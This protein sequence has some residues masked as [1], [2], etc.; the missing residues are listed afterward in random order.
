MTLPL[1][2]AALLVAA[3]L[4]LPFCLIPN[5]AYQA[6]ERHAVDRML[7]ALPKLERE[8]RLVLIDIDEN[9]L[10]ETGPWPWPRPTVARLVTTLTEHYEVALLGLDV[11]FPEARPGD[12]L[13]KKALD[14]PAVVLSQVFDFSP[15]SETRTGQLA[16]NESAGDGAQP[17]VAAHGYIANHPGLMPE[18]ASIGHISPHIDADGKVRRLPPR[19]CHRD[20][21]CTLALGLRM[22]ETLYRT[23]DRRFTPGTF[24]QT[25]DLLPGGPRIPLDRDRLI[26]VPY[27][28]E[29]GGFA[30]VSAS[31]ILAR[32]LEKSALRGLPV[33][34][35]GTALSLGDRIV[36]PLG[37]HTPGL[38]IHAHLLSAAL[39]NEFIVPIEPTPPLLATGLLLVGLPYLLWRG[40]RQRALALLALAGG[41]IYLLLAALLRLRSGWALPLAPIPLLAIALALVG[42]ML[43]RLRLAR[44]LERIAAESSH[45]LPAALVRRL[46]NEK[47]VAAGSET[48][49]LSVLVADLRGFTRATEDKTPE[50]AARLVQKSLETLSEVIA[51]HGGT[52]EKYTGDGLMAIW[53]APQPDPQHARHAL[54]AALALRE[55]IHRLRPWFIENG[56]EPLGIS[57][58]INTGRMAV[59]IFGGS[60]RAWTAHGDAVNLATRI[61]EL[62]RPLGVDLLLGEETARA[63][64]DSGLR[65]L[66]EHP[67]KGRGAP[68]TVYGIDTGENALYSSEALA[69][70][71]RAEM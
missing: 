58:G 40:R 67:V 54:Q 61:E 28:V 66:G 43:E 57:I 52:I 35:G 56:Y 11:V 5:A 50:E 7:R 60:H 15:E 41:S 14:H 2:L 21:H 51:G 17:A 3:L 48:R 38:E 39:D 53:G 32:R 70:S 59:G 9:S 4:V 16:G 12:E 42:P 1:R 30:Y 71:R 19:V 64:G 10:A 46:M 65:S 33:L 26:V 34:L 20:A 49:T 8:N 69:A 22:A 47:E 31:D 62:T 55:S 45:F 23:T 37:N 29:P 68:V 25:L 13:L 44:Q 6:L 18:G 27:R 24:D 63:L 36:T